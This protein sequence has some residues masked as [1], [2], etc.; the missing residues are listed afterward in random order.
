MCFCNKRIDI[1]INC[2]EGSVWVQPWKN[3]WWHCVKHSK[4]EKIDYIYNIPIHTHTYI[5]VYYTYTCMCK[6]NVYTLRRGGGD[7]REEYK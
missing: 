7:K 5:Y 2:R 1:Y 3:N 6:I 4:Q